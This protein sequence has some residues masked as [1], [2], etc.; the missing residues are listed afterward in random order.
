MDLKN[1]PKNLSKQYQIYSPTPLEFH[2]NH[3][4]LCVHNYLHYERFQYQ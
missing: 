3:A 2:E 1:D 4:V